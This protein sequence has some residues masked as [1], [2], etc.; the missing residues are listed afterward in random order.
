[1]WTLCTWSSDG[2]EELSDTDKSSTIKQGGQGVWSDG[3]WGRTGDFTGSRRIR[4]ELI[5]GVP[6][7]PGKK[8]DRMTIEM[9]GLVS[10]VGGL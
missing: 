7:L 8:N 6:P 1:M 3:G 9:R 5:G 10:G 4:V 2:A